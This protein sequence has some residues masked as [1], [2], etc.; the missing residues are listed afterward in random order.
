LAIG[1]IP[2]GLFWLAVLSALFAI[3]PLALISIPEITREVEGVESVETSSFW[4]D[5]RSG[6]QYVR[7]W[8]GLMMVMLMAMM[9]NFLLTPAASLMPFLVS[10]Y[11]GGGAL[12]L[13]WMQSAFGIGM[14]A[15]GLALGAWGG[16]KKRIKTSMVGLVGL[17]LGLLAIG[18]IPTGLFWLAVLSALFAAAMLPMV[19]GPIHAIVQAVIEPEMQGRVF[20]LMS[21]LSTAMS[22]LGLIIAGPV[23]DAVGVQSWYLVGGIATILMAVVGFSLPAVMNIEDNHRKTEESTQEQIESA[24]SEVISS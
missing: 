11:F 5:F 12:Q 13:G 3:L 4:N 9:I 14:I 1:F 7:G 19:N 2:T 17:G 10:D 23:A 22:P 18:F 16:F 8:P 20:T 21:S 15:G 24:G 6:L